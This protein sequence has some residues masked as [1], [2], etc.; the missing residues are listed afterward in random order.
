MI[1]NKNIF[2]LLLM[3]ISTTY[4]LSVQ[5]SVPVPA[6]PQVAAKNYLLMD[7]NSGRVLAEKDADVQIEPASITKLMTSY[8][9][10]SEIE[11]GRLSLDEQVLISEKA[12]RMGGSRM[13][14]EVGS[15]VRVELLLKG[16]IIQSGNDASVALAEHIAGG[17]DAFVALMN[18]YAAN[19][20]M[21]S[22]YYKNSTGWPDA[23][24]LT[25]A[26]DISIL[27]NAFIRDFPERYK[28]YSE[29]VFTY[30][31]IKQYNRNKLLWRDK[32]VD[33]LK[34]G[35]T[36]SAGYCLVSSALRSDMRLISVVLG[37]NSEDARASV[38]QSL[39]NYGFR[40]YETHKLYS[41][42][43]S[44]NQ[45]RVWQG[46]TDNVSLGLASDLHVTIPRG[47][48]ERMDALLNVDANITAPLKKGTPLGE[49]RIVLDDKELSNVPLVALQQVEKG[50]VFQVSKDYILKLFD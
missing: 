14:L 48:Y 47:S 12:W 21:N 27:A 25:T 43:E 26:R 3:V 31:N 49:V 19:L 44:L 39:L 30:N 40:F 23:E 36:D 34:T 6:P 18:Q 33:G 24:H 16:L 1:K 42:G 10:Y 20:G 13:Y 29:K 38:S 8:V 35:H 46:D 2:V 5:A 50:N 41:A 32:S 15:K 45:S 4:Q 7:F 11:S 37:T 22:T 9:V 28:G 17:E